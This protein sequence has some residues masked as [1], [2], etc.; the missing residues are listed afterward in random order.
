MPMHIGPDA[1]LFIMAMHLVITVSILA[2]EASFE[3]WLKFRGLPELYRKRRLEKKSRELEKKLK[4][5]WLI[6]LRNS[7]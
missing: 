5:C 2:P 4:R 6:D 3:L 1:V 7:R